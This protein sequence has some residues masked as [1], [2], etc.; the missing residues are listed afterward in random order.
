MTIKDRLDHHQKL[1]WAGVD[2]EPEEPR[3]GPPVTVWR[4]HRDGRKTTEIM[5]EALA[6]ITVANIVHDEPDVARAKILYRAP[7]MDAHI[8]YS[9]AEMMA[10]QPAVAAA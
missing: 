5:P 1:F 10:L 8:L 3:Y 9:V 2:A 7:S 4:H 6:K